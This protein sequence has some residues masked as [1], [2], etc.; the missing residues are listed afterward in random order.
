MR[1]KKNGSLKCRHAAAG[2]L[3]ICECNLVRGRENVKRGEGGGGEEGNKIALVG[4]VDFCL[5]GRGHCQNF[6]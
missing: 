5:F 3:R 6:D 4:S 1:R 2:Q